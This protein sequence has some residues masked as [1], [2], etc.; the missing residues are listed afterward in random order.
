[1]RV[2]GVIRV[3]EAVKRFDIQSGITTPYLNSFPICGISKRLEE[4]APGFGFT[5]YLS[6]YEKEGEYGYWIMDGE[7]IDKQ[8]KKL[9]ENPDVLE[10]TLEIWKKIEVEFYD[11]ITYLD[12]KGITFKDYDPFCKVYVDEYSSALLTEYFYAGSEH[13]VSSLIRKYPGLKGAIL[14]C[15]APFYKPF[16]LEEEE[17]CLAIARELKKN[18]CRNIKKLDKNT[19]VMMQRHHHNFF[20]IQNNYK[21]TEKVTIRQFFNNALQ[22]AQNRT[23]DAI[24]D[25]LTQYA[26]YNKT[27]RELRKELSKS[28]GE[29]DFKR[30]EWI[31]RIA[32]WHDRRK[33]ANLVADYYGAKFVEMLSKKHKIPKL[34]LQF[35]DFH[36][37]RD[38][39]KGKKLNTEV[40]ESRTKGCSH[41]YFL[42]GKFLIFDGDNH[43][44][45]REIVFKK[46]DTEN[47]KM[48]RGTTASYGTAIQGIVK[49]V[50]NPKD[51]TINS[52]EILVTT[53]TRPEFVPIMKKARA[54]IT[55]DGGITSHAAVISRELGVPCIVGTRIG[56]QVLRTGDLIEIKPNHGLITILAKA[57]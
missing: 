21:Y 13:V 28:M 41:I 14:E 4:F 45:I 7:F 23:E 10:K 8:W 18:N 46:Q 52:D 16:V 2:A 33:R 49:V 50:I 24:Q 22:I 3:L 42:N 19:Y 53:M 40:L 47:I 29:D 32:W 20:W 34:L 54:I 1:M 56:T 30:L 25:N 5:F 51:E 9:L 55:D 48:F 44:K 26:N 39:I 27:M 35:A 57:K 6:I 15:S 11:F 12:K 38:L 36:E 43:K 31:S 17:S 37:I